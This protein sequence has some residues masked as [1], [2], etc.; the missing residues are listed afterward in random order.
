MLAVTNT[1]ACEKIYSRRRRCLFSATNNE[2]RAIKEDHRFYDISHSLVSR[3]ER[4]PFKGFSC[5]PENKRKVKCRNLLS[6]EKFLRKLAA[7]LF[8]LLLFFPSWCGKEIS[9][10]KC[11][12]FKDF[13][14]TST[15]FP[16]VESFASNR[17]RE[18]SGNF[19]GDEFMELFG[20]LFFG[21]VI[22]NLIL[23]L[24]ITWAARIKSV[25]CVTLNRTSEAFDI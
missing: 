15:Q 6:W 16:F 24:S 23:D 12:S 4:R 2:T 5:L 9:G 19:L 22:W 3:N 18:D 17:D 8:F 20:F 11:T 25:N 1:Q 13:L 14:P 10:I 7:A 21:F